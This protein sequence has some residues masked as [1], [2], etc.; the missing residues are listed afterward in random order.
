VIDM[1]AEHRR[2]Q[3]HLR[4]GIELGPDD[5]RV[6]RMWVVDQPAV[7]SSRLAGPIVVRVETGGR[8]ALVQSFPDPR[9]TRS[10]ASDERGHHYGRSDSGTLVVSVPFSSADELAD[11]RVSLAD[12]VDVR[13]KPTAPHEVPAMFDERPAGMGRVLELS[14]ADLRRSRD[15]DEVATRLGLPGGRGGAGGGGGR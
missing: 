1:G 3:Q 12:T 13:E 14:S 8:T 15:W 4:V 7:Q 11:V 2:G 10:T 5:V 6:D 9:V